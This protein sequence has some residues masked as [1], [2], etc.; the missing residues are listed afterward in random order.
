MRVPT[1]LP[2]GRK[3]LQE[4]EGCSLVA[5]QDQGGTWTI[6]YGHTRGVTDGMTCTQ[7]RAQEWLGEDLENTCAAV[8]GNLSP[9]AREQISD[10]QFTAFV[11]FAFNVKGWATCEQ[12]ARINVCDW[13]GAADHWL[14][15]D[16]EVINGQKVEVAGLERRRVAELAIFTR[17]A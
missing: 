3:L 9:I 11:L 13:K 17:T 7:E 15:Y 6:G 1:F 4:F 12:M 16:H 5:Y 8:F 10:A 2:E 14:L